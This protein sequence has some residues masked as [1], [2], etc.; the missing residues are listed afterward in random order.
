LVIRTLVTGYGYWGRVLT[1]NL[2][3][4]DEFFVAGVHDPD[5]RAREDAR[6]ANLYTFRTFDDALA[7]TNPQLVVIASPIGTIIEPA[8][9]A[10]SR[11][12]NVMMAKPGPVTMRDAERIFARADSKG[13]SVFVDYTMTAARRF[14]DLRSRVAF[15]GFDRVE[16]CR[17]ATGS[18]T[19]APILYD[20]M[21]HDLALVASLDDSLEWRVAE[22]E[23]SAEYGRVVLEAGARVAILE[24]RRDAIAAKRELVI[25]DVI[26]WDQ[27]EDDDARSPVQARLDRVA[28]AL[29]DGWSDNRLEVMRVTRLLEECA[30]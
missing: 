10:V 9:Q 26:V 11:Y 23:F 25:D 30:A 15:D 8:I 20:M 28:A 5:A 24:A 12:A 19:T 14:S 7:F 1:R 2:L 16:C 6:S 4:H 13:R 21:V 22:K 29:L 17:F 3:A 27:L 18:R